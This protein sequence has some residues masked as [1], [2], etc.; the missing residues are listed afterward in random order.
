MPI[1][2][3]KADG[4]AAANGLTLITATMRFERDVNERHHP[5]HD[6]QRVEQ[7]QDEDQAVNV[8]AGGSGAQLL[9]AGK[10]VEERRRLHGQEARRQRQGG[11]QRVARRALPPLAQ[12]PAGAGEGNADADH[13]R[14]TQP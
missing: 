4:A 1:E 10:E 7:H 12:Q 11:G 8:G 6:V 3:R 13:Q 14:C 5:P 2:R 9:M